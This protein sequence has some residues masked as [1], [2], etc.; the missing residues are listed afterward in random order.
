MVPFIL[1]GIGLI[2]IW[3]VPEMIGH[4]GD[5][6]TSTTVIAA[7]V[8]M[9]YGLIFWMIRRRQRIERNETIKE[10]QWMLKDQVNSLLTVI[11]ISAEQGKYHPLTKEDLEHLQFTTFHI[12][13]LLSSVSEE[14]LSRWKGRY[15]NLFQKS[16]A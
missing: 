3:N 13:K 6:W 15:P 14:S 5:S 9:L 11:N 10:I 4:A 16:G 7:A 8:G 2:V 12:A 1:S